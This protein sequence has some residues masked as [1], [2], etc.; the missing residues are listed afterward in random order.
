MTNITLGMTE[1][2]DPDLIS[3]VMRYHGLEVLTELT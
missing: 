3:G 2:K 1:D